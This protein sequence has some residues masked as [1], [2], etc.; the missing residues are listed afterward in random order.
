M[1]NTFKVKES[2]I[3]IM[4]KDSQLD[5]LKDSKITDISTLCQK[6]VDLESE[7]QHDKKKL[8]E[9]EESLRKLSLEIIPNALAEMNL[10]SLKLADGSEVSIKDFYHARITEKNK[11]LAY[12]WLR[13]HGYGDLIKNEIAVPFGRGEDARANELLKTLVNTGYEPNQKT[14]VHPQTLKAFVKEQLESG[15]ELPLDLLGAYAGQK[16]VIKKGGK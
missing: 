11:S 15:K 10:K 6:Q 7:I 3:D 16:T 8:G 12:K 4:E 14:V 5:N 9:K 13:D 1:N 2:L